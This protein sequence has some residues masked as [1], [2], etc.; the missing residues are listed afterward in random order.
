MSDL[1]LNFLCVSLGISLV[2]EHTEVKQ[3]E[4]EKR[5]SKSRNR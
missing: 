5:Q 2:E 3:S 4:P 1:W